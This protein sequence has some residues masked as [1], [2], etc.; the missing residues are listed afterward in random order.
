MTARRVVVAVVLL[1]GAGVAWGM[2][3]P[4]ATTL[5]TAEV[6]RGEFADAVQVRGELKASR[7][8]ILVA[9]AD[10]GELRIVKL[11]PNGESIAKGAVVVEFDASTVERTLQ[12]KRSELKGFE[13]EIARIRAEAR[14]KEE[15]AVTADA[16][17]GYDVERAELDYSA[18]EILPRVEAEQR[19]LKV[20]DAEQKR[21][22]ARSTVESTRAGTRADMAA[23]EQKRNKAR[24]ELERAERQVAS[25]RLFA[26]GDG[27]VNI[28]PNPRSGGFDR[29][30]A[31]KEG[32]RAWSGAPIVELPEPA[33]LFA[34][35]RVDEIERGQLDTG[36]AVLVRVQA[37]PDREL[38]GHLQSIGTL[39]RA[40]FTTW[41][42]PRTFEV[43]VALDDADPRL[44]PGMTATI[45]VV[46][47]TL[48]GVLLVP[49]SA[50]FS[51]EGDEVAWVAGRRGPEMRRLAVRARNADVV[52]VDSGLSAG[53]RVLLSD[54]TVAAGGAR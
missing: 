52:A 43:S 23:A 7:S 2:M 30:Q 18:R 39:A 16:T 15:A 1:A 46:V 25:L 5:P 35:A 42:P 44:R 22:E 53:D 40:D 19:R 8:M 38:R 24:R 21:R 36:Q 10:A 50:V 51:H 33:S 32:D 28:L 17:A 20:L 9:P 49:A 37:V 12:E 13:A 34:S 14:G 4:T 27:I 6:T 45:R 41:P 54:P 31:F 47:R 11:A 3:R 29:S 26:P 48:A